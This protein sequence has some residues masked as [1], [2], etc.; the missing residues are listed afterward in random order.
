MMRK[1]IEYKYIVAAFYSVILFLDRLD[2]TIIN[3]ALPAIAEYF[4]VPI[5]ATEWVNNAFLLALAISLPVSTWLGERFDYLVSHRLPA[6][7]HPISCL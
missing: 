1:R 2:L 3:I 4:D 7:C 5:T 6:L